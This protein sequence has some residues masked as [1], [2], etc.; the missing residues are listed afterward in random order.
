MEWNGMKWNEIIESDPS[1]QHKSKCHWVGFE[2]RPEAGRATK[3]ITSGFLS[4]RHKLHWWGR[5]V[6]AQPQRG[7]FPDSEVRSHLGDV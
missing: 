2:A 3:G 5:L 4:P 1:N 7:A 6:G